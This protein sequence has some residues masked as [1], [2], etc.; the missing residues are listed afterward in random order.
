[1][2]VQGLPPEGC[3][4]A[5]LREVEEVLEDRAIPREEKPGHVEL[6][7]AVH[8]LTWAEARWVLGV[9]ETMQES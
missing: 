7:R 1:M 5:F 4:E 2:R 6:R 9:Q 3:V 8:G